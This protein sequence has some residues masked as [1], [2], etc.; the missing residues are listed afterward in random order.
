[1]TMRRALT[2]IEKGV[3]EPSGGASSA[4]KQ[5]RNGGWETGPALKRDLIELII[6]LGLGGCA[7]NG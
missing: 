5:N 3:Q 2:Q 6:L 7:L 1:M 4:Q